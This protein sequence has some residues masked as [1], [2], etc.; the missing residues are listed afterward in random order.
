LNIFYKIGLR[1]CLVFLLLSGTLSGCLSNSLTKLG[2]H[3]K[4]TSQSVSSSSD[5]TNSSG[6]TNT[7]KRVSSQ[8][9]RSRKTVSGQTKAKKGRLPN[10]STLPPQK[11]SPHPSQSQCTKGKRKI[12]SNGICK[13]TVC[14]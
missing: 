6:Q 1:Y 10:R 5:Q 9:K 8:K 3:Y 4:K 2:S 12:C 11:L 14:K 7:K 13:E